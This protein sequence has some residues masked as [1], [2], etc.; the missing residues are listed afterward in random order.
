MLHTLSHFEYLQ[1][2]NTVDI[3]PVGEA[4][5]KNLATVNGVNSKRRGGSFPEE[6]SG[7]Q[8]ITRSRE[9]LERFSKHADPTDWRWMGSGVPQAVTLIC[10]YTH[11]QPGVCVPPVARRRARA[12]TDR[13]G[14]V[15]ARELTYERGRAADVHLLHRTCHNGGSDYKGKSSERGLLKR[16][17]KGGEEARPRSSSLLETFNISPLSLV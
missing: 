5:G 7:A 17:T 2:S 10:K 4:L 9:S 16:A 12:S 13:A 1:D 15:C 6:Q 14:K 8:A 3:F 11:W